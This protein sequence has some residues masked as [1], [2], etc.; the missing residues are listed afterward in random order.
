MRGLNTPLLFQCS[1]QNIDRLVSFYRAALQLKRTFIIDV[2]TA[3]VLYELRKLGNQLPY[4]SA[5]YPNIKVFFPYSITR[6]IFNEIGKD[7][8]KRFSTFHISRQKLEEIQHEVVMLSRPSMLVDI[9]KI[10]LK[11]GVFIYSLWSGYRSSDYQQRFEK[12]LEKVGFDLEILHASGHANIA[13][14]KHVIQDLN[15]KK[16]IPI[17]TMHP[18]DF[19]SLTNKTELK[20][21]GERFSV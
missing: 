13:D 15:P 8:A 21:D 3:N 14:I 11:N 18:S 12:Y 16:V 5:E 19:L 6:K 17:H 10:N 4:P 1:S 20:G 2:Y 7:Y 9:E